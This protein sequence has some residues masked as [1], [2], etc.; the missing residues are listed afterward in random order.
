MTKVFMLIIVLFSFFSKAVAQSFTI[1]SYISR[2]E[3]FLAAS[4]K[5]SLPV[6]QFPFNDSM[7]MK[8]E[9]LPGQRLGYKLSHFTET[10]KISFHELMRSCLSTQGYLTVTAVMFNE[11]IQQKF[12]PALGRNE[13]WVE[14]F[15][16]PSAN[17]FWG[18]KLEGHHLSLNFTFKGNQMIANSP[19][20]VST[21]PAN[22]ITDTARAGLIILYKQEEL[23][24]QLVHSL[25]A[26]Q[27]TKGYNSR[28]KTAIVYSEQDKD[29]IHVP[30]EGIYYYQLDK[31]QQVLVRELVAEYFN[32]FNPGDTPPINA[33]CNKKLRFFYVES[34]EKGKAHYYRLENGQQ[35]IEYENY[36]NHIH[37]FWR[38]NN[39]FGKSV[40]K[41]K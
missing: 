24:R 33:F 3:K 27:Q 16:N 4:P 5:D 29:N 2:A 37:C 13:Y 1:P 25:T 7:R 15:G 9:R 32:N 6:F 12:E 17:D 23:G 8:W 35:I 39:D 20:L 11:D 30:D 34:R 28:K 38:T 41:L 18:W 19:F 36:D 22:S 21:N 10:Q 26:E 14:I 40:Y 31:N